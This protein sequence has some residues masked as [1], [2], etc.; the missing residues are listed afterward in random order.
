M[1][2]IF[3]N[4]LWNIVSLAVLV[5]WRNK[6]REANTFGPVAGWWRGADPLARLSCKM[7]EWVSIETGINVRKLQHKFCRVFS[8]VLLSKSWAF[9]PKHF[10]SVETR[11]LQPPRSLASPAWM[12]MVISRHRC[13]SSVNSRTQGVRALWLESYMQSTWLRLWTTILFK[14]EKKF[15]LKL[16]ARSL[17]EF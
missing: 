3:K 6:H 2:D 11:G 14:F 17:Q 5:F 12:P 16:I 4:H 1:S 10:S 7:P 13:T 9:C 15:Y 8:Q